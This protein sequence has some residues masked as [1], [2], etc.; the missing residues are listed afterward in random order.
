[1][2]I[3][4]K[5]KKNIHTFPMIVLALVFFFSSFQITEAQDNIAKNDGCDQVRDLI[6]SGDPIEISTAEKKVSDVRAL[7]KCSVLLIKH[8]YDKDDL[9]N[10]KKMAKLAKKYMD[11]NWEQFYFDTIHYCLLLDQFSEEEIESFFYELQGHNRILADSYADEIK[12]QNKPRIKACLDNPFENDC[13]EF[14]SFW[15]KKLKINPTDWK[16][17]VDNIKVYKSNRFK[18]K[19]AKVV[20]S[21]LLA[22][23]S[24]KDIV[25]PFEGRSYFVPVDELLQSYTPY[26]EYFSLVNQAKV[27][28]N[29][30]RKG[31]LFHRAYNKVMA[32]MTF[33]NNSDPHFSD[34]EKSHEQGIKYS[35]MGEMDSFFTSNHELIPS[36]DIVNDWGGKAN[37]L[38][39]A[40]TLDAEYNTTLEILS[41][42]YILKREGVMEFKCPNPYIVFYNSPQWDASFIGKPLLKV[43]MKEKFENKIKESSVQMLSDIERYMKNESHQTYDFSGLTMVKDWISCIKSTYNDNV[44]STALER[45]ETLCND[46][47]DFYHYKRTR[48]KKDANEILNKLPEEIKLARDLRPLIDCVSVVTEIRTIVE[49][50]NES[51]EGQSVLEGLKVA[52]KTIPNMEDWRICREDLE[53]GFGEL[54]DNLTKHFFKEE[55]ELAFNKFDSDQLDE[56]I[57]VLNEFLSGNYY[58]VSENDYMYKYA[59][60][61]RSLLLGLKTNKHIDYVAA[62]YDENLTSNW[63]ENKKFKYFDGEKSLIEFYLVKKKVNEYGKRIGFATNMKGQSPVS[64]KKATTEN[65]AKTESGVKKDLKN[66][67]YYKREL[68]S[69]NAMP[70]DRFFDLCFNELIKTEWKDAGLC[71]T[72]YGG[73][74]RT[75][76]NNELATTLFELSNYLSLYY[77]VDRNDRRRLG[78]IL[79]KLWPIIGSV[80]KTYKENLSNLLARV[81]GANDII[82]KIEGIRPDSDNYLKDHRKEGEKFL[83]SFQYSNA[84]EH[85]SKHVSE[86]DAGMRSLWENRINFS[87]LLL[88]FENF[89]KQTGREYQGLSKFKR[90]LKSNFESGD[91]SK[92]EFYSESAP[93][94]TPAN[95]PINDIK[96]LHITHMKYVFWFE[97][98]ERRL[99]QKKY[100][101]ALEN[102][103]VARKIAQTDPEKKRIDVKISFIYDNNLLNKNKGR[104]DF[105]PNY[106]DTL[107]KNATQRASKM[108]IQAVDENI[109]EEKINENLDAI[110]REI[111]ENGNKIETKKD[112]NLFISEVSRN[113]CDLVDAL[114][115]FYGG[116]T[117]R[118]NK[119][120]T[121]L[122]IKFHKLSFSD[123]IDESLKEVKKLEE[124]W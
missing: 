111:E 8:F 30:A 117:V 41:A 97:F 3:I 61:K 103:G 11:R 7:R 46:L 36:T 72:D 88:D 93:F 38:S 45:A 4:N 121:K 1:M 123:K 85:F 55:M 64:K 95:L 60:G 24:L 101:D 15:L 79:N 116:E 32:A 6:D 80:N 75:G 47:I 106:L 48:N 67:A 18:T 58:P 37:L 42:Y 77:D 28:E 31:E 92:T 124:K 122:K 118:A 10:A 23:Q 52:R 35:L 78:T 70:V 62:F 82:E 119:R 113:L 65:T 33:N 115:A 27:E 71:F 57:G 40:H 96:K 105:D 16:E 39:P 17:Y 89:A 90:E 5:E 81:E 120:V 50:Y 112:M 98:G 114:N 110:I 86:V 69:W 84:F 91:L 44:D 29:N 104:K 108:A 99:Y 76:I 14:S 12:T 21:I 66:Y 73:D 26:K 43:Q 34:I 56:A 109:E 59:Y 100:N 2:I 20:S 83:Y 87:Q 13:M 25:I 19:N 107:I 54:S 102:Y 9:N 68:E 22:L 49:D 53:S 51:K 94:S 74:S 63:P